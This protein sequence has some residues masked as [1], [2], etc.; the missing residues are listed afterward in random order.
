MYNVKDCPELKPKLNYSLDATNVH[1]DDITLVAGLGDRYYEHLI[2]SDSIITVKFSMMAGF[3]MDGYYSFFPSLFSI[4]V[5]GL[6]E[7]RG[8]SYTM[9]GDP[10]VASIPNFLKIYNPDLVGYSVGS[11]K[12]HFCLGYC[13]EL[14]C[15]N[16]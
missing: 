7:Y 10:D 4:I 5:H 16:F 1:V 11:R 13:P 8:Q 15:T 3:L 6:V 14:E 12:G 2:I 9:G